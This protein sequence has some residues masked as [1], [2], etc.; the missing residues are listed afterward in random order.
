MFLIKSLYL[1]LA[2]TVHSTLARH[3]SRMDF[4]H[5]INPVDADPSGSCFKRWLERPKLSTFIS[6]A[7]RWALKHHRTNRAP[8]CHRSWVSPWDKKEFGVEFGCWCMAAEDGS[9]HEKPS[10]LPTR[11][12]WDSKR[13]EKA[14]NISALPGVQRAPLKSFPCWQEHIKFCCTSRSA[15]AWTHFQFH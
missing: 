14:S 4:S 7:N 2:A 8:G 11:V 1:L 12:C 10:P 13:V 9:Q 6:V 3:H 15:G 5:G